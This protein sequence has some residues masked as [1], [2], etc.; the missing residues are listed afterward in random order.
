[1]EQARVQGQ[2]TLVNEVLKKG[3]CVR[4]GACVGL[5]PYFQYHD[6]KVV[7]SDGCEASTWRCVQ[8][9]PRLPYERASLYEYF[10]HV[11]NVTDPLGPHRQVVAA[12]SS[13]KVV[14]SGAQYG[15]VVTALIIFAIEEGLVNSAVLTDRGGD[16]APKGVLCSGPKAVFACSGSRYT[17]SAALSELNS[18]IKLGKQRLAFVGLP[19]QMEALGRL[20]LLEPDGQERAGHV[21]LKI[22]LFCTWALDYRALRSYL[23]TK[24]VVDTPKRYDIPPPPSEVFVVEADGRSMEFPLS[25]VRKIIQ[26]GCSLCEDMTAEF[27][28]ISVGTLEGDE[29][30]NTVI[31]RTDKGIDL[32]EKALKAGVLEQKEMPLAK[33][34]HLKEAASN[35]RKRAFHARGEL[36]Q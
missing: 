34:E 4:C 20:S 32:F 27:A 17:A 7:V 8:V 16:L 13:D 6:G 35:K 1:M 23:K 29:R 3:I 14:R 2:S 11:T 28:D 31:L 33:L 19:C 30:W 22:G 36:K 26:S 12:T 9:C 5:C 10:Y 15:G 18:A 24:G 21:E 25:E